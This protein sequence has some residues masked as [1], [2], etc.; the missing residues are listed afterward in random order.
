MSLEALTE[1]LPAPQ[2]KHL[3]PDAP[4]PMKM[5][6]AKGMAPLPP[7]EM[8]I[9]LCGL[10]LNEDEKL[11][12]AAEASLAKLPDKLLGPALGGN[13]PPAALG[14]VAVS[15]LERE[16][17]LEPL[18]LNRNTPDDALATIA[19][20]VPA[21]IGEILIANQERCLR[22]RALVDGLRKNPQIIR[23]SKD[24]LFDFLVRSG[25]I[26]DDMSEIQDAFTRLSPTEMMQ[27]S[28]S[29]ALPNAVLALTK[30]GVSP[31][32]IAEAA[33][34]EE[35]I[36]GLD[37]LELEVEQ[38]KEGNEAFKEMAEENEG[39]IPI[40]KLIN[41]LNTAQKIA[42]AMKGNKEARSH[43]IRDT[44]KMVA[45]A[46]IRSPR[47]TEQEVVQAANSRQVADDVIRY[48]AGSRELSRSYTVKVALAKNPKTPQPTAMKLLTLL[49]Q[50]EL[51][52]I[53]KSKNVSSAISTHAKRMLQRKLGGAK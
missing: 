30:D 48:I 29:V 8:V 36:E 41:N 49:R 38:V 39:S 18:V 28:D 22:S 50:S 33:G 13:L 34:D 9:V 42:L 45:A 31:E 1:A 19:M 25:V 14:I 23:S 2:R 35:D 15:M 5:M 26:Y 52:G 53:A 17:M 21:K 37:E 44:N 24:R 16:E 27:M 12:G 11:K 51:K 32:E 3:A 6:A 47:I 20:Q 4:L 10:T 46:T 43:L 40:L 7:R